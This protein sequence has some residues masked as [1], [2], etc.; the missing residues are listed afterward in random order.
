[1]KHCKD[2]YGKLPTI[3]NDGKKA[4]GKEN[5]EFNDKKMRQR[6][7]A[8]LN[9]KVENYLDKLKAKNVSK[10]MIDSFYQEEYTQGIPL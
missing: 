5:Q 6:E 8:T 9:E 4:R 3:T 1:M 2:C 10:L 7:G